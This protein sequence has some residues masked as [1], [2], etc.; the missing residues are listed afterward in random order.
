GLANPVAA[1][2]SLEMALRWS[3]GE[4]ALA[5]RLFAAVEAALNNGA[6]TADLGG[7]LSSA[8]MGTAILAAL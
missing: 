6:R 1:I 8:D 2:L 4:V 3:L 5:D 7:S